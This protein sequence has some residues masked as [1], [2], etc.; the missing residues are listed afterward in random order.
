V[1]T[2][3]A[4]TRLAPAVC[5]Q[6]GWVADEADRLLAAQR[7]G[8][9]VVPLS[10]RR[11]GLSL[12][13]AYRVQAGVVA[14]RLAGGARVV[15]HKVG[16]T[17]RAMQQQM[18]VGEPDSGVLL[19]DMVVACG[20]ELVRTELLSPRVEAEIAF[21]LGCDLSGLPVDPGLA[22]RAVSE[23]F[24]ALE[25]IDT[26]FDTWRITVADSVA[27]NAS[28]ARVVPGTMI[29]F[30]PGWDLRGERLVLSIDGRVVAEGEGRAVLGDPVNPLVWLARRLHRLGAGLRAGDL[31]LA[32]SVHA[33]IPLRAGTQVQLASPHLPGVRLRVT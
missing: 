12:G 21:R 7:S 11:P 30:D 24:L 6:D 33:S 3:R 28:C 13:D 8:V 25:V 10:V 4:R 15:G 23:V 2:E 14:R 32:G 9:P 29:G 22:R 31:V 17:S 27:D 19:D 26:R 1:V 20:G 16:V 18:G 5:G